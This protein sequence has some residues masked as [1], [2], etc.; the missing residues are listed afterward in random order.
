M[1][2]AVVVTSNRIRYHVAMELSFAASYDLSHQLP[3]DGLPEVAIVGRSNVGKSSIVG[4]LSG[5]RKLARTSKTPGRTRQ[6]VVFEG[7]AD[8]TPLRLVDL[9]GYGY[10]RISREERERWGVVISTYIEE[11]QALRSI[12]LLLDSRR[13]AGDEERGMLRW[14]DERGLTAIVVM[15]KGD[16][17][18]KTTRLNEV[19]RVQRELGLA[20]RPLLTSAEHGLGIDELELA[21]IAALSDA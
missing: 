9:P 1:L 21:I 5:Q 12:L 20:K 17:L 15:T 16:K 10:A 7:R 4:A 8:K 6:F 2:L 19:V 11:R 18:P 14:C 13:E 3:S